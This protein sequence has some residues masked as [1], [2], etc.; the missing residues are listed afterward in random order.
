M[1][2]ENEADRIPGGRRS[3]KHAMSELAVAM[4]SDPDLNAR[5]SNLGQT[6]QDLGFD[7]GEVVQAMAVA[8]AEGRLSFH[9][10][11]EPVPE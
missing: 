11:R 2:S 7:R 3:V 9:D 10:R 6:A 5:L 4:I 8:E 1:A